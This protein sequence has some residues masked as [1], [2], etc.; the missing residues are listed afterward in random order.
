MTIAT[1]QFVSDI[2]CFSV[3]DVRFVPISALH[4]DNVVDRSEKTSWYEGPT[5]LYL[6]EN[7]H[8]RYQVIPSSRQIQNSQKYYIIL[9]EYNI[10]L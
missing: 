1:R 3:N 8:I 5:L 6:L 10:I 2:F 4:G 9:L 7:I